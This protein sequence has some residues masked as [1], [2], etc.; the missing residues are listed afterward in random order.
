MA[1]ESIYT[2]TKKNAHKDSRDIVSVATDII[3]CPASKLHFLYT[4]PSLFT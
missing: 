3:S 4:P 1:S 2:F